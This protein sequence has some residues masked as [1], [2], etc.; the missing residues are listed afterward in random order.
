MLEG[1]LQLSD[2]VVVVLVDVVVVGELVVVGVAVVVAGVTVT[3]T[4]IDTL[5]PLDTVTA[6]VAAYVP[7]AR[8]AVL[9]VTVTCTVFMMLPVEGDTETQLALSEAVQLVVLLLD[10]DTLI[11]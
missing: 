10:F 3:D 5:P 11:D 9:T 8:P 2:A 6:I 4:G 1:G 7:G